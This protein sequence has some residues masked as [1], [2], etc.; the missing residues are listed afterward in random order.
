MCCRLLK[1]KAPTCFSKVNKIPKWCQAM[2]E[3]INA[4]VVNKTWNM[5]PYDASKNLIGTE[6]I[7]IYD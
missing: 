1:G 7:Y 2:V 5:V 4:M 3:E 6:W